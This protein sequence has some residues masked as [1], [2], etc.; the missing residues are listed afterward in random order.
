MHELSIAYNLV[1]I[2]DN[3]AFEAE[4]DSV[5]VVHLRLGAL[6]GVEKDAL[7]FA[8]DIAAQ[9]TRLED[10]RL[11]IEQLP[12]LIYC[13][14]CDTETILP[15]MQYFLCPMCDEPISEIRQGKELELS[16]LEY[17]DETTHS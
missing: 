11:E 5:S 8:Y 14:K 3:A 13:P 2:A 4:V 12:I 16:Y 9:G 17:D 10:S 1:E 15:D 6:S 7:L